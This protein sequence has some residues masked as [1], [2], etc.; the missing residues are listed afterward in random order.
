MDTLAHYVNTGDNWSVEKYFKQIKDIL[1]PFQTCIGVF[2]GGD[3]RKF[4][5]GNYNGAGYTIALAINTTASEGT[6]LFSAVFN[7]TLDSIVTTGYVNGVR[8]VGG[9]VG[10]TATNK[11]L[12]IRNCINAANIS[13]DNSIGGIIGDGFDLHSCVIKDC[14]N[15]G[16]ITS[17]TGRCGGIMGDDCTDKTMDTVITCINAGVIT[18]TQSN[19]MTGGIVGG[20]FRTDLFMHRCLNIGTVNMPSGGSIGSLIGIN[21]SGY[22]HSLML[23]FY[24]KQISKLKG[25][26][27]KDYPYEAE[28]RLT[29]NLNITGDIL[30]NYLGN[31]YI[32]DDC[33]YPRLGNHPAHIVAATPIFLNIA[34]NNIDYDVYDN[35]NYCFTLSDKYDVKWESTEGLVTINGTIVLLNDIGYDT[36]IC[37]IG[38]FK[39]YIPIR[40][41]SINNNLAN[42]NTDCFIE[43]IDFYLSTQTLDAN[44]GT[45]TGIGSYK[46]NEKVEISAIPKDCYHFVYWEDALGNTLP[47]NQTDSIIIK[48]DSVVIA[49]FEQDSF[50]IIINQ[51]IVE[52]GIVSGNG[53]YPCD[54]D[55]IV[56]ATSNDCYS[57]VHWEDEYGDVLPIEIVDTIYMKSNINITAVFIRDSFNLELF[58]DD[59]AGIVGKTGYYEC[60]SIANIYATPNNCYKFI[61]WIESNGTTFDTISTNNNEAILVNKNRKLYAVFE[62]ISA[63]QIIKIDNHYDVSPTLSDYT[64]PIQ[65][66]FPDNIQQQPTFDTLIMKI[67]KSVFRVFNIYPNGNFVYKGDTIII[68]ELNYYTTDETNVFGMN[69]IGIPMLGNANSILIEVLDIKTSNSYCLKNEIING[70]LTIATCD[71]GITRLIDIDENKIV[72][73]KTIINNILRAECFCVES[74]KYLLEITDILGN[75]IVVKEWNNTNKKI[76]NFETSVISLANGIYRLVMKSPSRQYYENFIIEK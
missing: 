4:F 49:V 27:D 57:F 72:T 74:G 68:T 23:N 73:E 11:F 31:N 71:E 24:D 43:G 28:G 19:Y 62:D 25:Y 66:K 52:A 32:Y 34:E 18:T 58:A 44:K 36:L 30:K 55:I 69:L 9:I 53:I 33:M 20:D 1:E 15:I 2:E 13:G 6:G 40:I 10:S 76:Y 42:I 8:K 56:S 17:R 38:D 51:N 39:K 21:I 65:I 41:N 47:F 14:L 59:E 29:N 60:G 22:K 12:R 35:I 70:N 50:S 7:S 46:K 67:N 63:V 16:R 37:S 61:C 26:N 64:L 48:G 5:Q 45:V 3:Y 75:T 54:A